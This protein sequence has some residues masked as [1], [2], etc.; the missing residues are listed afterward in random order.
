MSKFKQAIAQK[1]QSYQR[2]AIPQVDPAGIIMT[3]VTEKPIVKEEVRATP[4]K[5]SKPAISKGAGK[6]KAT[7][8][9]DRLYTTYVT[10]SLKK[11]IKLYAVEHD[12]KDKDVVQEALNVFLAKNK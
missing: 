12:M 7:E 3:P 9:A 1:K 5:V 10:D 6:K 8:T 11:E 4:A 2:T